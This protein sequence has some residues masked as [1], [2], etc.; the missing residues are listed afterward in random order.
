[1]SKEIKYTIELTKRQAELLS[2][3]CDT[4]ARIIE[5]QD[6]TYQQMLEM[7]WEK[8]CK[9]ATGTMMDDTFEGGWHE[10]REDAEEIVKYI[11]NR[12]WGL[13]ANT[14][15]GIHYDAIA[16]II[17]DMYQVIRHQLWKDRPEDKRSR[18]TV[19]AFPANQ[20][21]D[22]PLI[23]IAPSDGFAWRSADESLPQIDEEVI[24]L[25]NVM[26]GKETPGLH[27]CFAHRPD[28]NGWD[29]R[30]ID[31][32]KVTHHDPVTYD[33]WNIPGVKYWMPCP[34]LEALR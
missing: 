25:S 8:R 24:A 31:T 6:W 33:G 12:F 11:K 13:P 26:H 29:G 23:K 34:T 3:T 7:A 22:A 30:D 2:W 19:D 5:G 16:D 21:G 32:G 15:N 17:W 28:P 4:M 27:I 18:W 10:M 9:E 20:I 14:L 1:M